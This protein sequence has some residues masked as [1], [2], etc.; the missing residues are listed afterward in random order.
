MGVI[1]EIGP[2]C[3][4]PLTKLA[5]NRYYKQTFGY[6]VFKREDGLSRRGP[7]AVTGDKICHRPLL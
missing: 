6:F 1:E 7:A 5:N 4:K 2:K 3:K